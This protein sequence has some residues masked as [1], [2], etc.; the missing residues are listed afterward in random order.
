M[1]IE[2]TRASKAVMVGLAVCAFASCDDN[3]DNNIQ[4]NQTDGGGAT[5]ASTGG[6]TGGDAGTTAVASDAEA[7]GVALEVN[8]GEVT[9]GQLALVRAQMAPVTAFA[10]RMVDEHTAANQRLVA[11]GQRKGLVPSDSALRRS[12]ASQSQQTLTVLWANAASTFDLAYAQSQ[13]TLHMQVLTVMDTQVL[14]AVQDADLRAELMS[15][16][17]AVAD[18]LTAAQALVATL[19]GTGA[20]GASGGAGG[21]GGGGGGGAPGRGAPPGGPPGGGAP[22]HRPAPGGAAGRPPPR[23]RPA[24]GRGR[25]RRGRHGRHRD[26]RRRRRDHLHGRH[27]RHRGGRDDRRPVLAR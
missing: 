27:A 9:Q 15:Q 26:D 21:A 12:L 8:T 14:P 1:S 25:H 11:L 10:N 2:R 3:N 6:T 24:P 4:F 7:M 16:R 19:G 23:G 22:R 20:G 18:H 5:D 13:V 17:A